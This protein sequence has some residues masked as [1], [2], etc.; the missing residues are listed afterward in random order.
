MKQHG[1][2]KLL[3]FA[4]WRSYVETPICEGAELATLFKASSKGEEVRFKFYLMSAFRDAEG[5]FVTRRDVDFRRL[6]PSAAQEQGFRRE[7]AFIL[8]ACESELKPGDSTE[9]TAQPEA[10]VAATLPN[11]TEELQSVFSLAHTQSALTNSL[12]QYVPTCTVEPPE[13]VLA[14]ARARAKVYYTRTLRH[15]APEVATRNK[16]TLEEVLPSSNSN[17]ERPVPLRPGNR[18]EVPTTMPGDTWSAGSNSPIRTKGKTPTACQQQ[19]WAVCSVPL[20]VPISQLYSQWVSVRGGCDYVEDS[21]EG[22]VQL[23]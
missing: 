1:K 6:K 13:D 16:A 23:R 20:F 2:G 18:R 4:D 12:L 21:R 17:D 11:V 19:G 9:A 3:K 10:R 8:A 14:A 5:R 22:P 15:A 7:Q